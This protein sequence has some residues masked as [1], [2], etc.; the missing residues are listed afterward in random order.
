MT[1]NGVSGNNQTDMFSIIII[2]T[3]CRMTASEIFEMVEALE[4]PQKFVTENHYAFSGVEAFCLLC[5]RF[6]SAGD[7]YSLAM[8][9]DRSQSSISECVN[10]LVEMLDEEWEHLLGCDEEY[11][12]HPSELA[13]YADAIH[14]RGAPLKSV[15]G[16]IDCTIRRICCPGVWQCQAYSG[17]KKFHALKFQALMLP[18]GIIGHLYG[19]FEGRRHDNIL[20]T[21][22][23][24]LDC[25]AQFAHQENTDEDTPIEERYFQISGDPAY[26]VGLNILSP[27]SGPG[28]RTE[29]EKEWNAEMSAVRIEVEHGFGIVSNTWPF[30]N[31]A[32][33]MQ[34][35]SSPVGRYYRVGV[36]LT[37]CL[38][39]LRP[40]Q[41]AQYFDCIPPELHEYLH[42]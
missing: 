38:N 33:K 32:W 37:N 18:N 6:R 9:Y 7:M 16:F 13:R 5:A 8:L 34:L 4:I 24:L 41:V 23:G 20:H 42:H 25:L 22:S 27:F 10:E 2:L 19:P 14:I 1:V 40:N 31:A 15:A 12:L 30:L 11:L 36:L 29:E 35:Y 28:E 21:E 26:G 39:C 17:H 3:V